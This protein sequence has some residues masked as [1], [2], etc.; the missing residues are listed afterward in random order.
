MTR[1]SNSQSSESVWADHWIADGTDRNHTA[2]VA[3]SCL[4][5]SQMG[6]LFRDDSWTWSGAV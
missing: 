2:E 5:T 6:T 4:L 1:S 3:V